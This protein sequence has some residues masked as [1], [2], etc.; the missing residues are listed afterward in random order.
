MESIGTQATA[1]TLLFQNQ[2]RKRYQQILLGLGLTIAAILG[3]QS[4]SWAA[5][6]D[7]VKMAQ[8]LKVSIDTIW[9]LIAG[10]LVFFMNCGFAMLEAGLC[11]QKNTVNILTKNL[12]TFVL[13]SISFWI[14]GFG[15]MFGNGNDWIGANGFFL[16]GSDNSP[17]TGKEYQ[18]VFAAL[19]WAGVPLA[20]K[21][22]FQLGFASTSATIVS[23]AMAER[24]KLVSF[25]IFVLLFGSTAYPMI[26]HW[27]W[28]GGWLADRGFFDFA[29]SSVVHVVGGCAALTGAWLLKPRSGKY[30]K[31]GLPMAIPG[32]S[33]TL[34]TLGCFILWLGWF[35]FNPGST[36]AVSPTV[37]HIV[38]VT[39]IAAAC[40]GLAATM[41]TW[42]GSGKPDL[43]M[44]ISGILAGL[45]AITASC[46]FVN[47]TSA[48]I[49]GVVAGVLVV[50]AIDF[51]ER[52]GIDDPVGA[53]SVHLV[54]GVWGTL[55]VGLFS[56][57]KLFGAVAAP[58]NGLFWGGGFEQI[59]IQV[60]GLVSIVITA[61]LASYGFWYILKSTLGLRVSRKSEAVGLD[62]NEHSME[63]YPDFFKKEL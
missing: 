29:G 25:F 63:A 55:A 49:I 8:E 11:R 37:A 2:S 54:A 61:L 13:I 34:A 23:G 39:N 52:S 58:K 4:P 53:V 45:V 17:A 24:I 62:T 47:L 21:F 36:L 60:M 56:Q 14:I 16:I 9:V 35:G 26:G 32:H 38:V 3:W 41:T 7:A 40:G 42:V 5:G 18:G 15:L 33:M 59:G 19:G 51:I 50:F 30:G 27:V 1:F 28:G 57:G 31:T 48:A 12:S 43:I 6:V 46:A 10:I 20:A 22:F 44:L